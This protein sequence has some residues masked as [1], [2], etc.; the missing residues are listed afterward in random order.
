MGRFVFQSPWLSFSPSQDLLIAHVPPQSLHNQY[1]LYMM[2]LIVILLCLI[3]QSAVFNNGTYLGK[4][5]NQF[6]PLIYRNA[7]PIIV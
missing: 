1:H 4:Q 6:L 3:V 2:R 5:K 7:W